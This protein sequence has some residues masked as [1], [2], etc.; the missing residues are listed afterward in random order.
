MNKIIL[1]LI[2]LLCISTGSAQTTWQMVGKIKKDTPLLTLDK[3]AA[4][5]AFNTNISTSTEIIE[6]FTDVFLRQAE[7]GNYV[8][9]FKG[10]VYTGSFLVKKKSKKLIAL[11][12]TSCILNSDS[13]AITGCKVLYDGENFPYCSPCSSENECMKVSSSASLIESKH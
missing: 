9:V 13:T 4:L 8:L 2:S 12:S 11:T 5:K 7:D 1:A 10:A 3:E 6:N